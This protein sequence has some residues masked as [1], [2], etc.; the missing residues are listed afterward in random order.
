MSVD[1]ADGF[2]ADIP[3]T[4]ERSGMAGVMLRTAFT[5]LLLIY[6]ERALNAETAAE[7][8]AWDDAVSLLRETLLYRDP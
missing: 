5:P 6:G 4:L 2:N 7:R 8:Q 1:G 3:A